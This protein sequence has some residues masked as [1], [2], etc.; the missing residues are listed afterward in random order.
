MNINEIV[1]PVGLTILTIIFIVT[2]TSNH[3][4]KRYWSEIGPAIRINTFSI[5]LEEISTLIAT[6][7]EGECEILLELAR[8]IIWLM[9]FN[10]SDFHNVNDLIC[11]VEDELGLDMNH[12]R[13]Q[14]TI[15]KKMEIL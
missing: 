10:L 5:M 4:T 6:F 9:G 3:L 11:Q 15:I 7:N 13:K 14:I 1:I 2:V 8:E 12:I